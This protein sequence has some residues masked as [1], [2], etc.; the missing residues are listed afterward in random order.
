LKEQLR[1]LDAIAAGDTA[2]ATAILGNLIQELRRWV[3]SYD[4][5]RDSLQSHLIDPTNAAMSRK[6]EKNLEYL[7]GIVADLVQ[8]S[9]RAGSIADALA[10]L[11][12]MVSVTQQSLVG[13]RANTN[14][15]VVDFIVRK[16]L[17]M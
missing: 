1:S 3:T 10:S 11:A 16:G 14:A 2:T 7:Q 15:C 12:V 8:L 6:E 5:L 4:N 9:A 17:V 13:N